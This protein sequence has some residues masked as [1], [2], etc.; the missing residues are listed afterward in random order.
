MR[1]KI[2]LVIGVI[3]LILS[4]VFFILMVLA[5]FDIQLIRSL[6]AYVNYFGLPHYIVLFVASLV[7]GFIWFKD[8]S[9]LNLKYFIAVI[10]AFGLQVGGWVIFAI[11][12]SN[13][14]QHF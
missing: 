11:M 5:Y 10:A 4:I 1:I 12:W 3:T 14:M 9:K 8:R 2:N 7:N 13:T 6:G